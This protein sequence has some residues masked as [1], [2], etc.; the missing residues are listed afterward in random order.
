MPSERQPDRNPTGAARRDQIRTLAAEMFFDRGYEATTMREL[1][2]ALEI[3]SA[4]LYYFFPHKEQILFELIESVITELVSGARSLIRRERAAELKLAAVVVNHVVLHALRPKESTLG[5]SELRSLS[6]EHVRINVRHRDQ[7]ERVVLRVLEDGAKDGRFELIEP[8]L[9]AYAII[10]QSSYV[11]V[12]YR[13]GGRLGLEQVAEA[14]V[15]LALRTV[16]AGPVLG[17]DV[18]RLVHDANAFH[19]AQRET[20]QS[21]QRKEV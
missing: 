19:Q 13:A 12:W 10:A 4:S 5:D 20:E 21:V 6:P 16:S 9:T 11:G 15:E 14:Y 7:Y 1:A 8:K 18:R 17:E 3:K 2:A